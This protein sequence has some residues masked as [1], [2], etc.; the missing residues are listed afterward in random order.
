MIN[1]KVFEDDL[2]AG[3]HKELVKNAT[4]QDKDNLGRAVDYLNSAIDIF[5]DAG[6]TVQADKVLR[7]LAKI[8]NNNVRRLTSLHA[9]QEKGVSIHDIKKA[10]Q[11]DVVARA[12]VNN[13]LRELGASDKEII[14]FVGAKNY[15]SEEAARDVLNPERAYSKINDWLKDP[16]MPVDPKNPQPGESL[17]FKSVPKSHQPGDELVFN[18]LAFDE[19]DAKKHSLKPKPDTHSKG[20]TSEKMIANLKHHG[21]VFNMADDGNAADDLLDADVVDS[22]LE[23]HDEEKTFEDTD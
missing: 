5:E 6:M 21:T 17:S 16:T 9:L 1:K 10:T 14:E 15:M 19:Q 4:N 3:M 8:A 2:I 12:K 11:G 13:A 20:L 18:S 22:P 23:V 7:I